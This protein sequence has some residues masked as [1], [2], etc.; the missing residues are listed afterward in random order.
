MCWLR[1]TLLQVLRSGAISGLV[2]FA[3][4]NIFS[5]QEMSGN[6]ISTS[7]VI[8]DFK[9]NGSIYLVINWLP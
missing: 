2:P 4:K 5:E 9:K 6:Q 8:L 3:N 7:F 1:S